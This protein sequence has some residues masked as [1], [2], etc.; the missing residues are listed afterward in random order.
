MENESRAAELV[1]DP[2]GVA[3]FLQDEWP[4]LGH[5]ERLE[6]IS[7][8]GAVDGGEG[9]GVLQKLCEHIDSPL[10]VSRVLSSIDLS[11]APEVPSFVY[12]CLSSE[13]S[14][15][16]ANAVEALLGRE[17]AAVIDAVLPLLGDEDNRVRGNAAILLWDHEEARGPVRA[18]L[19]EM[20]RSEDPWVRASA[21][22]AAV[23][24]GDAAFADMLAA[25]LE[26]D[27]E[28]TVAHAVEGLAAL[29]D[30]RVKE[31]I[32]RL[33]QQEGRDPRIYEACVEA[34]LKLDVQGREAEGA[35]LTSLV[36]SA[37]EAHRAKILEAL[38]RSR[39]A[40]LVD[41]IMAFLERREREFHVL[42]ELLSIVALRGE[43]RHVKGLKSMAEGPLSLYADLVDE[44]VQGILKRNGGWW[45]FG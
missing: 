45:P 40:T 35:L 9:L 3:S 17:D 27:Y 41:A 28:P 18:A 38:G 42:R 33:L 24:I 22:F 21:A 10:Y 39:S 23:R 29:E 19:E 34:L 6:L 26:D 43:K 2:G 4:V 7:A 32:P 1:Q 8:L 5:Y 20:A 14:R 30:D 15:V 36:M 44:A 16:R 12:T 31:H 25:F 13:S 37:D 11:Q